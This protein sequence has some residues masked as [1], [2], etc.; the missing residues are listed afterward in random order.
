[1]SQPRPVPC[2][3]TISL[4]VRS[5]VIRTTSNSSARDSAKCSHNALLTSTPALASSEF[6][7]FFTIGRHDPHEVPALVLPHTDLMS[8]QPSSRTAHRIVPADTLLPDDAPVGSRNN[9]S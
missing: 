8:L 9:V 3:S 7:K 5:S 6:I 1:M 2:R 4:N